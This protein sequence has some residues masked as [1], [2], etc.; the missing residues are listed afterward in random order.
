MIGNVKVI[1]LN[2]KTPVYGEHE[3]VLRYS[4]GSWEAIRDN[5][6][7]VF[8][9][10]LYFNGQLWLQPPTDENRIV[11]DSDVP[12]V[13]INLDDGITYMVY[14]DLLYGRDNFTVKAMKYLGT[15]KRV[16]DA[17]HFIE[18]KDEKIG[19]LT[20]VF[21]SY[22]RQKDTYTN[23][24]DA[25]LIRVYMM[26]FLEDFDKLVEEKMTEVEKAVKDVDKI[27]EYIT[28]V[29]K[30]SINGEMYSYAGLPIIEQSTILKVMNELE[31]EWANWKVA[32]KIFIILANLKMKTATAKFIYSTDRATRVITS[33]L[34]SV[35]EDVS[36]DQ[37][38]P[39]T[40]YEL[41]GDNDVH[42]FC[43]EYY[44]HLNDYRTLM[45]D[46]KRER[47]RRN[48]AYALFLDGIE[49]SGYKKLEDL[50][51]VLQEKKFIE[52][53]WLG[54]NECE[55]ETDIELWNPYYTA[56]NV[57]FNTYLDSLRFKFNVS[58][59]ELAIFDDFC[60]RIKDINDDSHAMMVIKSNLSL[61]TSD[62]VQVQNVL[63]YLRSLVE[64]DDLTLAEIEGYDENGKWM[65]GPAEFKRIV[66]VWRSL[67]SII[68]DDE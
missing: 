35:L 68:G 15:V 46:E 10:K 65:R 21:S 20:Y 52:Q 19:F 58:D 34:E 28:K 66:A 16:E 62:N 40:P 53:L 43:T 50:S 27:N 67:K 3:N 29:P 45:T 60:N 26:Q 2:G 55:T 33:Y 36:Y 39:V 25:E 18:D 9:D 22:G 49:I 17:V 37:N 6:I 54:C 24:P 12:E 4:N 1:R 7:K 56:S 11:I 8:P 14:R 31:L 23:K 59:E 47:H 57:I 13:E 38:K 61:I 44:S 48:G 63:G 32:Q 41:Y 30:S 51:S 42:R 64:R 5:V